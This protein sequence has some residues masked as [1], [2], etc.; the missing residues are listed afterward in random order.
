MQ[1]EENSSTR[2]P[3]KRPKRL[4]A[5]HQLLSTMEEERFADPKKT[6]AIASTSSVQAVILSVRCANLRNAA[7]SA[8]ASGNTLLRSSNM[9]EKTKWT[10]T[11][12]SE[13]CQHDFGSLNY[14][15]DCKLLNFS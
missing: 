1:R 10:R 5:I 13:W 11:K 6:F 12:G 7:T 2:S 3:E 8:D 15:F 9:T 14:E 4:W